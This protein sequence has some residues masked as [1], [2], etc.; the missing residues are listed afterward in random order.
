LLRTS[1]Y[2]S[3]KGNG[4]STAILAVAK[5]NNIELEVIE[6]DPVKGV[7]KEYLAINQLGKIPSFVGADGY[8]LTECI[9]IAIYSTTPRPH[10]PP[11]PHIL[12]FFFSR[13]HPLAMI[14][15]IPP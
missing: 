1:T 2:L 5:A 15:F 10:V 11:P 9:A 3:S 12:F 7:P 4:R 8:V 13:L 14:H 6:T